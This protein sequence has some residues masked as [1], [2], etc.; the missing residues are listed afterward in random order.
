MK[1]TTKKE[2]R[3]GFIGSAVLIFAAV[4]VGLIIIYI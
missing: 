2:L 3:D 4:L 1:S